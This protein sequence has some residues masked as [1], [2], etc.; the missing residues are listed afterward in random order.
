MMIWKVQ[1]SD[2]HYVLQQLLLTSEV[3]FPLSDGKGEVENQD[4]VT[5]LFFRLCKIK[6]RCYALCCFTN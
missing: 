5:P 4:N 2:V 1:I 3:G 6:D